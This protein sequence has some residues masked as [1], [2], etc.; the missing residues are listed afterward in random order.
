MTR[1]RLHVCLLCARGTG[2]CLSRGPAGRR[3]GRRSAP[4]P[5]SRLCLRPHTVRVVNSSRL[6]CFVAYLVAYSRAEK[7]SMSGLKSTLARCESCTHLLSNDTCGASLSHRE[8]ACVEPHDWHSYRHQCATQPKLWSIS[9]LAS[10]A[11]GAS[12]PPSDGLPQRGILLVHGVRARRG[13][14]AREGEGAQFVRTHKSVARTASSA[15]EQL[16][17]TRPKKDSVC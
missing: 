7:W 15:A 16:H 11:I 12:S 17:Y 3:E 1:L 6:S 13:G 9:S 8:W 10:S 4:S 5:R 2:A 14:V